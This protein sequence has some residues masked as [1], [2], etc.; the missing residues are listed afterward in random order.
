MIFL[1]R[2]CKNGVLITFTEEEEEE[3]EG[4]ICDFIYYSPVNSTTGIGI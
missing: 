4:Y 1:H 3:E 2:H